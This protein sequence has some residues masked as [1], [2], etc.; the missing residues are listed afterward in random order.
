V[1]RR[2][3]PA[4]LLAAGAALVACFELSAPASDL[5]SISSLELA[6]PSVVIGDSLRDSTGD[7]APLRVE[8][9]DGSGQLVTDA[10]VT[11]IALDTGLSVTGTGFVIGERFRT[12]PAKIVAHVQRG[13]DVLQT[14]EIN[15][16]VVPRPDSV[17][18]F[19]FDTLPVKAY[20][21]TGI[22]DTSWITSDSIKVTVSNRSRAASDPNTAGV[23]SW[24]VRYEITNP[25][26]GVGGAVSAFF[27]GGVGNPTVIVDTTD[28]N[29]V[30]FRQVIL[31]T[32]V[33]PPASK[34]R[35]HEVKV[36]ATVRERGQNVPGSPIQFV[37][38]F[39][40]R[41]PE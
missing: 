39:D 26:E 34:I 13:G 23:R 29:G 18:P 11:F 16:D 28:A 15:V 20:T 8:A 27:A 9:F 31:R 19:G 14:P 41:N 1:T 2:R 30:A 32:V 21:L 22:A 6:W 24:I 25:N 33:L 17:S 36:T 7:P 40:I 10:H 38:P 35:V 4:C 5:G 3:S 37:V 12:S